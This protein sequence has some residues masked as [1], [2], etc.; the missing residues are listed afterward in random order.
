MQRAAAQSHSLSTVRAHYRALAPSYDQKANATCKAAYRELVGRVF[1]EATAVLE[2]GAGS[3]PLVTELPARRR[4]ACDLSADMLRAGERFTRTVSDAQRLPFADASFDGVF[5][6]NL[7]EHAPE[8]ELV[9]REAAR[10]LRA[11]GRFLAVTP[12]GDVEWLLNLL[13]RLRLKLPE[14][15]HRFLDFQ[16]LARLGREV[17]RIE[18]H[19]RFLAL[20]VG[21]WSVAQ[22][23]DRLA[24]AGMF[25]Y[26]VCE[27]C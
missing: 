10:V 14:G 5:C 17:F 8:P 23:A 20:P 22:R 3:S 6:I 24:A 9:V 19:R 21:P 1:A 18:E 25:Q 16:R 2:L 7:L 26:I 4:V 13:E 15:P 11:S 12:N 27:K